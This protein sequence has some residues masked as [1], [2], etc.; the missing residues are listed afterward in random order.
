MKSV[1]SLFLRNH[2][3]LSA[4]LVTLLI[5]GF[6]SVESASAQ[7]SFPHL[8]TLDSRDV[9]TLFTPDATSERH[10][11]RVTAWGTYSMWEDTLNSSVD[12]VWIYS[13]PDEE[14][15]KPEWRIFPEGYP[16]YVGDDR[17]FDSH[18]LR[19][20]NRSFPKLELNDTHRYEMIIDGTGEPVSTSIVDWNFKNFER[21]DAHENNSGFL[22]VLV[23]ELPLYEAELCAVDSSDFPNVRVSMTLLR[24][25]IRVEDLQDK[26]VLYEDG[27]EVVIDSIDC[28]D[29]TRPVSVALVVDRSGSMTEPWGGSTRMTQ[30]RSAARGFVDRLADEDE[31]AL[32]TFGNGVTLDQPWT[33]RKDDLRRAID[34]IIPGGY[35]AMNDAVDEAIR[36]V[37]RRPDQYRKGVVLLSDGEDNISRIRSISEVVDLARSL[38]VPVFTI[39]LLLQSDDSLRA[40]SSGSGGRHFNVTDPGSIDSVFASIAELLFEKGCCNIWYRSPRPESDGTYRGVAGVVRVDGDSVAMRQGGYNAPRDISGVGGSRSGINGTR[41]SLISGGSYTRLVVNGLLGEA[42]IEVVDIRGIPI[43]G[44]VPVTGTGSVPLTVGFSTDRL[45]SGTYIARVVLGQSVLSEPFVV[46]R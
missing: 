29:R 16:I 9:D 32:Y 4:I 45:A 12:P 15:A 11:Y 7:R 1:R 38:D 14:W 17:M 44:P 3:P 23:E 6:L 43:Y 22:Y 28:G 39:G 27:R 21:R 35:T 37:A 41:L 24:D 46:V 13:F 18:G 34:R 5:L 33:N 19:V 36:G 2:A 30:V 25:S 42:T 40:L 10:R 8:F 26:I 31:G 20:N